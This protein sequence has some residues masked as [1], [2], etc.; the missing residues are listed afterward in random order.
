[1]AVYLNSKVKGC[2]KGADLVSGDRDDRRIVVQEGLKLAEGVRV[3][4]DGVRR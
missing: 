3:I 4:S 1:M 2:E